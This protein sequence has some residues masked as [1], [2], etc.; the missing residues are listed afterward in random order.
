MITFSHKSKWKDYKNPNGDVKIK[1]IGLRSGEKLYE[2]L[3]IGD[4]PKK[5]NHPKIQKINDPYILFDKLK[6]N[7]NNLEIL[8]DN[9]NASDAKKLLSKLL[10][11][12]KSNSEIVDHAYV[13]K[14]H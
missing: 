11:S 6:K 7:L 9:N 14:F 1:I 12:Y 8:I 10:K 5:T 3:L 4:N 13:E 2:E